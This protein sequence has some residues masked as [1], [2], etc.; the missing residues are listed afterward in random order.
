MVLNHAFPVKELVVSVRERDM[1]RREQMTK[2]TN[3]KIKNGHLRHAL[4]GGEARYQQS[5][6]FWLVCCSEVPAI[7]FI[8]LFRIRKVPLS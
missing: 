8:M 7:S 3:N 4:G 1:R 2:K 6:L 5:Y